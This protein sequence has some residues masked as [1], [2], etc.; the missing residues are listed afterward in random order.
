MK[1][2][3]NGTYLEKAP[4]PWIQGQ[5]I[6]A[7]TRV[8]FVNGVNFARLLPVARD[9]VMRGRRSCWSVASA[10]WLGSGPWGGLHKIVSI[11]MTIVIRSQIRLSV[12]IFTR[13]AAK[14][15]RIFRW[16]FF[17]SCWVIARDD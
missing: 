9:I 6:S 15:L 2:N 11:I 5:S 7:A 4:R 10:S 13:I 3:T 16:H 1:L 8:L 14:W 17:V 12:P